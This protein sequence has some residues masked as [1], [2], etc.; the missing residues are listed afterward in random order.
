[1][2]C[3]TNQ[4]FTITR[5]LEIVFVGLDAAKAGRS[6]AAK[7]IPG[8]EHKVQSKTISGFENG[9]PLD[10]INF[11]KRFTISF[12]NSNR[13]THEEG[14]NLFIRV[15]LSFTEYQRAVELGID[16][17]IIAFQKE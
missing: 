4:A 6:K 10:I 12:K 3:S 16:P 2:E 9:I 13:I 5:R 15:S 14:R 7:L 1:L 11:A 8:K 17:M